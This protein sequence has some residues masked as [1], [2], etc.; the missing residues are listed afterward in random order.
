MLGASFWALASSVASVF[1]NTISDHGAVENGLKSISESLPNASLH[2]RD[3]V[4]A[5]SSSSIQ[6][7]QGYAVVVPRCNVVQCLLAKYDSHDPALPKGADSASDDS[8]RGEPE[9]KRPR[10]GTNAGVSN[11]TSSLSSSSTSSSSSDSPAMTGSFP[12]PWSRLS[13]PG[14]GANS[15]SNLHAR[16]RIEE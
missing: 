12:H 13:V 16:L 6:I 3:S 15:T 10:L 11:Q 5:N 14:N 4:N 8:P 9:A 2:P 1:C 7:L